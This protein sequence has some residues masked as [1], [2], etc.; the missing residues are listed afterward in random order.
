MHPLFVIF[1]ASVMGWISSKVA[2]RQGRNPTFWFAIGMLFGI[3]G[4]CFLLL[5]PLIERNRI[6]L[7]KKTVV[8]VSIDNDEC[9]F[10]NK[11]WFFLDHRHQQQGPVSF[12]MMKAKWIDK[13]VHSLTYVWSDGMDSWKKIQEMPELLQAIQK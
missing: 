5:L 6:L 4:L 2:Q 11:E 12:F 1:V 3:F 13:T 7:E 10:Y 8:P 9:D